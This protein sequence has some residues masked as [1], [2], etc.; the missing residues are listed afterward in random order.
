MVMDQVKQIDQNQDNNINTQELLDA[1]KPNWFLSNENN[2]GEIWKLLNNEELNDGDKELLNSLTNTIDEEINR[3]IESWKVTEEDI[4]LIN[5]WKKLLWENDERVQKLEELVSQ[6]NNEGINNEDEINTTS[7]N[8]IQQKYNNLSDTEIAELATKIN[9]WADLI[10]DIDTFLNNSNTNFL[11]ENIIKGTNILN[12]IIKEDPERHEKLEKKIKEKVLNMSKNVNV[13]IWNNKYGNIDYYQENEKMLIQLRANVC[14]WEKLEIDWKRWWIFKV[15]GTNTWKTNMYIY[16]LEFETRSDVISRIKFNNLLNIPNIDKKLE[17]LSNESRDNIMRDFLTFFFKIK[18]PWMFFENKI[19]DE[20]LENIFDCFVNAEALK[21]TPMERFIYEQKNL[22]IREYVNKKWGNFN[23][24]EYQ[25]WLKE[26]ENKLGTFRT[27]KEYYLAVA[28]W[29][30]ETLLEISQWNIDRNHALYMQDIYEYIQE[31]ATLNSTPNNELNENIQ[32]RKQ[33]LYNK[34]FMSEKYNKLPEEVKRS[35]LLMLNSDN[36]IEN[37]NNITQRV[38]DENIYRTYSEDPSKRN[39]KIE[40]SKYL[41]QLNDNSRHEINNSAYN[42]I[43]KIKSWELRLPWRLTYILTKN[44]KYYPTDNTFVVCVAIEKDDKIIYREINTTYEG[45]MWVTLLTVPKIELDKFN[46]YSNLNIWWQVNE[47]IEQN[48]QR[49]SAL[50]N[51]IDIINQYN[52]LKN[53]K[54]YEIT[55][56]DKVTRDE[57]AK[58][59]PDDATCNR[60][61]H[62]GILHNYSRPQSWSEEYKDLF[63]PK[64][65]H[66]IKIPWCW[67]IVVRIEENE[68][69]SIEKNLKSKKCII[70]DYKSII[71]SWYTLWNCDLIQQKRSN[72]KTQ[73]LL[74]LNDLAIVEEAEN[75]EIVLKDL[76][77]NEIKRIDQDTQTEITQVQ[78]ESMSILNKPEVEKL[79][80]LWINNQWNSLTGLQWEI[81]ELMKKMDNA[82]INWWWLLWQ[83]ALAHVQTLT[84][85]NLWVDQ[86]QTVDNPFNENDVDRI[87]SAAIRMKEMGERVRSEKK[88]RENL[89]NMLKE[90]KNRSSNSIS[91]EMELYIDWLYNSVCTML[92]FIKPGWQL[93]SLASFVLNKQNVYKQTNAWEI[94]WWWIK[95]NWIV[96]LT[97]IAFAVAA[98]CA[99]PTWWATLAAMPYLATLL[100]AAAGTLWWMVWSRVWT[101][102]NEWLNNLHKEVIVVDWKQYTINYDSPTDV[103]MY[104]SWQ[105]TWPDFWKWLWK[106]FIIWTASTFWFM[107][108]WQRIGKWL[109]QTKRGEKLAEKIRPKA[110]KNANTQYTD[111]MFNNIINQ[112][113]KEWFLNKFA[114]EFIEECQEEFWEQWMDALWD[115]TWLP[116]LWWLASLYHSLTPSPNINVLQNNHVSFDMW[117]NWWAIIEWANINMTVYYESNINWQTNT[118]ALTDL[119]AYYKSWGYEYNEAT[120]TLT[121]VNDDLKMEN[122]EHRINVIHLQQTNASLDARSIVASQLWQIWWFTVNHETWENFYN[123]EFTSLLE[124]KAREL[125]LW[126][127]KIDADWKLTLTTKDN[128]TLEFLPKKVEYFWWKSHRFMV[129]EVQARMNSN[130]MDLVWKTVE[131]DNTLLQEMKT[132]IEAQYKTI[133]WIEIDLTLDELQAI[134]DTHNMK[135]EL[136]NLSQLEINAKRRNLS[137][138][139]TDGAVVRFLLEAWFCWSQKLWTDHI[140]DIS[141]ITQNNINDLLDGK[142]ELKISE[143]TIND[144]GIL[145]WKAANMWLDEK[146][147]QKVKEKINERINTIKSWDYNMEHM[148][149]LENNIAEISFEVEIRS[150]EINDPNFETKIDEIRHRIYDKFWESSKIWKE[151]TIEISKKE[152]EFYKEWDINKA[153]LAIAKMEILNNELLSED[154]TNFRYKRWL[155]DVELYKIQTWI[156]Q[157]DKMNKAAEELREDTETIWWR[158]DINTLLSKIE[159]W[160]LLWKPQEELDA[161]L[162][163][164]AIQ[165]QDAWVNVLW[166]VISTISNTFP[167]KVLDANAK[168]ITDAWNAS[169]IDDLKQKWTRAKEIAEEYKGMKEKLAWDKNGVERK[170]LQ[171]KIDKFVYETP[172][173]SITDIWNTFMHPLKLFNYWSVASIEISENT[174]WKTLEILQ[175]KEINW[176]IMQSVDM[177]GNREP[178][179]DGFWT[180]IQNMNEAFDLFIRTLYSTEKLQELNSAHHSAGYDANMKS[181]LEEVWLNDLA[182][183]MEIQWI[184]DCRVHAFTKQILFDTFKR[185]Q[186]QS[187][188][189]KLNTENN[190]AI[191]T[192]IEKQIKILKNTKMVYIDSS[193]S[194]NVRM[195]WKYQAE[196]ENGHMIRSSENAII[197]EHTY[198]LIEIPT[199]DPDWNITGK[200]VFYADAFYQGIKENWSDTGKVYDLSFNPDAPITTIYGRTYYTKKDWKYVHDPKI[201]MHM[202]TYVIWSDWNIIPITTVPLFRSVQWRGETLKPSNIQSEVLTDGKVTKRNSETRAHVEAIERLNTA[203]SEMMRTMKEALESGDIQKIENILVNGIWTAMHFN[204]E[205]WTRETWTWITKI[206][207]TQ[208]KY[209][210]RAIRICEDYNWNIPTNMQQAL[211]NMLN[212]IVT[213]DEVNYRLKSWQ[214]TD[215]D[216]RMWVFWENI[217]VFNEVYK[218]KID[219]ALEKVKSNPSEANIEEFQKAI[220]EYQEIYDS[221]MKKFFE[222]N[223]ETMLQENERNETYHRNNFEHVAKRF[224]SDMELYAGIVKSLENNWLY[225]QAFEI[226]Q[227]MVE[228]CDTL[229][230]HSDKLLWH[231]IDFKKVK[232]EMKWVEWR[233]VYIQLLEI[234]EKWI[235]NIDAELKKRWIDPKKIKEMVWVDTNQ[236][237]NS[238]TLS[239]AISNIEESWLKEYYDT[240]ALVFNPEILA[241]NMENAVYSKWWYKVET[242]YNTETKEEYVARKYAEAEVAKQIDKNTEPWKIWQIISNQILEKI[243]PTLLTWKSK[244]AIQREIQHLADLCS[245]CWIDWQKAYAICKKATEALIFQTAESQTR[246]M[247]DHWIN[248]ISWNIQKLNIY[249]EAWV[250][251]WKISEN[252][253]WKYKL[254]WALTHIF[255]DIWY[256]AIIS[257]WSGSFD[258]SAIHPFIS[259]AFFDSNIKAMLEGTGINANLISQ[260]IEAHDGT[261]LDFSRPETT[262]LSM[263]NLSDN[264]ALW[265]DKMAQLWSNPKLLNHISTLYALDAAWIDL[266][267]S[268]K[269]IAENIRK[270]TSITPAEQESLISAINELSWRWLDN[271]DFW[272]ISPLTAIEFSWDVPTLSMYKWANLMLVAEVCWIDGA[273]LETAIKNKDRNAIISLIK[274]TKFCSQIVKPLWDYADNYQIM[275][276]NWHE[277]PK[278]NWKYNMDEIKA[279][280]LLWNSVSLNDWKWT[281]LNYRYELATDESVLAEKNSV[282]GHIDTAEMLA[283]EKLNTTAIIDELGS[284]NKT[285]KGILDKIKNKEH[286]NIDEAIAS[287]EEV[288]FN[289]DIHINSDGVTVNKN[290]TVNEEFKSRFESLKLKTQLLTTNLKGNTHTDIKPIAENIQKEIGILS[291]LLI[292]E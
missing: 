183:I 82:S 111:N 178:T 136:W 6:E 37:I 156:G 120:H 239:E 263:V 63:V 249:L 204:V 201:N 108:A 73:N 119:I 3:I 94:I 259:K 155:L 163:F 35:V 79:Q 273:E 291:S 208:A 188:Q 153:R 70:K 226:R 97:S 283:M 271:I 75:W 68:Y 159:A 272:S 51:D 290:M 144:L 117:F 93:D 134:I 203:R 14:Y 214:A 247:W 2:L 174:Y 26:L 229:L 122:W 279:D 127:V 40:W 50:E 255:H 232:K 11:N 233:E 30:I 43:L 33:E 55:G 57:Y 200:N 185:T 157:I 28:N 21:D 49:Y 71:T 292:K 96:I 27:P 268:N 158:T 18:Q 105:L 47:I 258:G 145:I 227:Y 76:N 121:K 267:E 165:E 217:Q 46:T 88:D 128:V 147:L 115:A 281:V 99:I 141:K 56:S 52:W 74:T 16:K 190:P 86:K 234:Q 77:W 168:N 154:I 197:E 277:Y 95:K 23:E 169:N 138:V 236:P 176:V 118:N 65:I 167:E 238:E 90:M 12:K 196:K 113:E 124:F 20:D 4:N 179:A 69:T 202:T 8:I 264:M 114:W 66:K 107:V 5:V 9:I 92:D 219:E 149:T 48:N 91:N 221:D 164:L 123:P 137:N 81:S 212:N 85:Y 162:S 78:N 257:K 103:E 215:V 287:I 84:P 34:I 15:D 101:V 235:W 288:I 192:K 41:L 223:Q 80:W 116:I 140:W 173:N 42:N 254:M 132:K 241:I 260:G 191:R 275:D 53:N 251:G 211:N 17:W 213:Q 285:T 198:N 64:D 181:Y 60:N 225:E 244:A 133:T 59:W 61:W 36:T 246:V 222:Q 278:T 262:F 87:R 245:E 218:S 45:N 280:L 231:M 129:S 266:K 224:R 67:D 148:R 182:Q 98:I 142:T 220:K 216:E 207:E 89:K 194:W 39:L 186:L 109:M 150:I 38:V 25:A 175:W 102:I 7:K 237:F 125:W 274:W 253:I 72:E 209:L 284:L 83:I 170:I 199:I 187:L 161:Y 31:L 289:L 29:N 193:F 62:Q 230:E 228:Q 143:M 240:I 269:I 19:W 205:W 189:K 261:R 22:Y 1:M 184:E 24:E 171:D 276:S 106:E 256:A 139:I 58:R 210:R 286:I 177:D 180:Y 130:F 166:N 151:L 242:L 172:I 100:A 135:W 152:F 110:F 112:W 195:E 44:N 10:N 131:T 252:E 248:H 32:Q 282:Y 265:V 13:K 146:T 243:D 54:K 206:S 270:D 126:Q 250:R 160:I 104:L